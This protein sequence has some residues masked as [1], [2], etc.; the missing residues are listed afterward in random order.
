MKGTEGRDTGRRK[1][2]GEGKEGKE[3]GEGKGAGRKSEEEEDG[4]AGRLGHGTRC[5]K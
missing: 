3:K 4:F 1:V 5:R 2:E